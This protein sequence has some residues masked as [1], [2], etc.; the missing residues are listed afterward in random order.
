MYNGYMASAKVKS[1]KTNHANIK[2][3]VA[4]TMALCATSVSTVK[5][6]TQDF[7]CAWPAWIFAKNFPDYYN[8]INENPY[9]STHTS[10]RY[11]NNPQYLGQTAINANGPD[12]AIR[13]RTNV[14]NT[15]GGNAYLPSSGF[16]YVA[17]K[18]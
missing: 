16:D 17:I 13:I 10:M 9:D 7:N 8:K 12:N 3:F 6:G 2:S 15:S 5:V 18:E 11:G 14:G 4:T 1:A